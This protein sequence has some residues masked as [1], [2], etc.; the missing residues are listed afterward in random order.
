MVPSVTWFSLRLGDIRLGDELEAMIVFFTPFL[1]YFYL[2][3]TN[4][5]THLVIYILQV[6]ECVEQYQEETVTHF[7]KY[8]RDKQFGNECEWRPFFRTVWL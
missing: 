4:V 5:Y 1:Q 6:V 3:I 8:N 7:I 2:F